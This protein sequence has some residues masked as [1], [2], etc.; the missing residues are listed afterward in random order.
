MQTLFKVRKWK[1]V[2]LIRQSQI[3]EIL[4]HASPQIA[5][6]LIFM[7]NIMRIAKQHRE[8]DLSTWGVAIFYF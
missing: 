2:R 6:L 1:I 8:G 3:R 7:V 5:S 4:R